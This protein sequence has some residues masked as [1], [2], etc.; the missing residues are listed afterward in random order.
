MSAEGLPMDVYNI[1]KNFFH[2]KK[3][4][5]VFCD[6]DTFCLVFQIDAFMFG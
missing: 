6:S 4:N 2:K 3:K 1:N 5:T